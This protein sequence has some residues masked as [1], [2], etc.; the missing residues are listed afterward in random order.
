[1][2]R[3]GV[4]LRGRP[5]VPITGISPRWMLLNLPFLGIFWVGMIWILVIS[6]FSSSLLSLYEPN[7]TLE[8][9]LRVFT[10]PLYLGTLWDTLW[11]SSLGSFLA[12]TLAYPLAY[13]ISRRAGRSRPL[14]MGMVVVVLLVS[15]LIKMYAW[16]ILLAENSALMDL[17]GRFGISG[18]LLGTKAGVI[19]GLVY[20]SLPYTVL[21][22]TASIDQVP[23]SV[24]EA[25]AVYGA[26]PRRV[27]RAVVLP[28][29]TPGIATAL[30]FA[31]PLNLSAFL[32]PVLLGRGTVQMT[33]LQIYNA[34]AGGGAAANW[35]LASALSVVLMV[36]SVVF[37]VG[38]LSLVQRGYV[39]R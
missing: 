37:T 25:A 2:T 14:Y 39:R 20:A 9:Y 15:F 32:A 27:F 23:A 13:H 31:I 5:P 29:T 8:N 36:I 7:L 30:I 38:V 21:S 17:L 34:S 12:V 35:P 22:L 10:N 18:T 24:E 28:M 3:E 4:A 26:S 16:Q 1:M 19:M 33:A 6:F 11:M